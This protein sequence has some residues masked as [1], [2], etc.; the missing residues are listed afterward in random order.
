MGIEHHLIEND[1]DA[2]GIAPTIET[3]FVSSSPTAILIGRE[4]R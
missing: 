3:A 2:K 4:P 1:A